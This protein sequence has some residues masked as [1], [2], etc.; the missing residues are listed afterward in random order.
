MKEFMDGFAYFSYIIEI[1]IKIQKHKNFI[2]RTGGC[3]ALPFSH[4]HML[5]PID[6]STPSLQ[7][8]SEVKTTVH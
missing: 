1:Y 8:I 5:D 7:S 3:N 6:M 4:I 2:P